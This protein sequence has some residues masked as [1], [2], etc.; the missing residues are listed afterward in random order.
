MLICRRRIVSGWIVGTFLCVALFLGSFPHPASPQIAPSRDLPLITDQAST[1]DSLPPYVPGEVLVKFKKGTSASQKRGLHAGAVADLVSEIRE[2]GVDRV[3]SVRGEST[4]VLL[5]RYRNSPLVEYAEPNFQVHTFAIPNDPRFSELWGLHNTG[6]SGGTVDAD[7]DGPEAWD[8]QTGSQQ[9]IVADVDTGLHA[10]HADLAAN[11][12]TNPGEIPNNHIDDDGNGYVDDYQGWDFIGNQPLLFD[13]NGH[14]THTA[15][16]MG[17]VGNNSIGVVGVSWRVK[18]MSVRFLDGNGTGDVADGAQAIVYAASMGAR[19]ANN[20]WGC[21]PA[22]NCYSQV[23]EDAITYANTRGMLVVAAA[24]NYQNDNDLAPVYPCNSEQPNVI[25]VAATDRNDQKA[26]FSN[27][28][29]NSVDLSAPGVDILSTVP[30]PQGCS[31]GSTICDSSGY[32]LLSGTSMAAP[33]VSGAAALLLSQFPSL[34]VLELKALLLGSVDRVGGNT[35]TGGRLNVNRAIRTNFIVSLSPNE[36]VI[37]PGGS[38][39]YTVTVTT[40]NGFAGPV[41]LSFV[42]P[43]PSFAGTF[44]SITVSPGP[45]ASANT[46]LSV[47]HSGGGQAG[48]YQIVVQ[49]RDPA[50]VTGIGVA[51]L[52]IG[53]DLAMEELTGPSEAGGGALVMVSDRVRNVGTTDWP[54][55]LVVSYYLSSDELIT[56]DDVKIGSRLIAQFPAG[57]VN[58][59]TTGVTIPLDLQSGTYVLGAIIDPGGAVPDLDR[60]NNSLV[61][62]TLNVVAG[63]DR[64]PTQE[65]SLRQAFGSGIFTDTRQEILAVD[66]FGNVFV[67]RQDWNGSSTDMWTA[68]ID[69]GGNEVWSANYDSGIT[70]IATAIWVDGDGNVYVTGY[71][72]QSHW[73]L[74]FSEPGDVQISANPEEDF[75]TLK[76]DP[77]GNLMWA[78]RYDNGAEDYAFAISG[79]SDGNVYVTGISFSSTSDF[80]TIKYDRDGNQLWVRRYDNG[81]R[82]LIYNLKVDPAGNVY[83]SGT[84][85]GATPSGGSQDDYVTIKYDTN[86]TQR[87]VRRAPGGWVTDLAVDQAGNAYVTGFS[88]YDEA[89]GASTPSHDYRTIKYDSNGNLL[90]VKRYDH[91]M[92]D[93]PEAVAVD[94]NGNV[95]VTGFSL[96]DYVNGNNLDLDFATVKYDSSGNQQWVARFDRGQDDQPFDLTVDS[97][98]NAYVTGWSCPQNCVYSS[99]LGGGYIT[100]KY[101]QAGNQ[102]WIVRTPEGR[103]PVAVAVDAT[104]H[105]YVTG[106]SK[107]GS[108]SLPDYLTVKY[109]QHGFSLSPAPASVSVAVG[110]SANYT[111]TVHSESGFSDPVSVSCGPVQSTPSIGCAVLPQS[112]TPPPNGSIDITMTVTTSSA[113]P[114]G[115]FSIMVQGTSG[116]EVVSTQVQLHV[117]VP[118]MDLLMNQVTPGATSVPVGGSLPITDSVFNQGLTTTGAFRIHYRLSLNA[119]YGDADDVPVATTRSVAGLAA[120]VANSGST[121]IGIPATAAP[122]SYRVCG[123]ADGDG[124]VNEADEGN[125]TL[126]SASTVTLT[127]ADL[128]LT[129]VSPTA[130]AAV[131]GGLLAVS[132]TVRNQGAAPAAAFAVEMHLS[133]DSTY[134]GADDFALTPT[135]SVSS[136]AVG[137]SSSATITLTVPATIGLGAYYVCAMADSA[138]VINEGTFEGNNTACSLSPISVIADDAR[139]INISTRSRVQTGDNVMIGGFWISGTGSKTVL[140]RARGGSLGGAPFNNP[141]VLANPTMQLYSGSTVIAQNSDWQTTDPLCGSPA[142]ACGGELEITAT[143]LDPCQPNPG[144]TVAPPGCAQESALLVTL[145]PGGY[146]AIVSGVGGTSGMGLVEVFEISSGTST[147]VNISTRARVQTGDNVMIG[148]FWIGGTTPKNVLIRARGGS[149]GGAPFNNPGVLAN[150]YM[151]LYSGATVIAQSDNWQTTDPLCGSPATGCGTAT[152]ITATGLDPC[153]PNPG[154]TVAPPG[155]SQESAILVTLAPGGYTTIV[156]GVGGT[157]GMGLVEVFEVP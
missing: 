142:T 102:V 73:F 81:G 126:C 62:G 150:P 87:W 77:N 26:S 10:T 148:G 80:A 82:E 53:T 103:A 55:Y 44:N 128:I 138:Q 134:G 71:R 30:P 67:T 24:G 52:A 83:V 7:I 127:V 94:Q 59:S 111:V 28:G 21:G 35:V 78:R 146:T 15:G 2:I 31:L 65:W 11:I 5:Q 92:S 130:T 129:A 156:S 47:V 69:S 106:I 133:A 13:T 114:L 79:D 147:L 50:G 137:V 86:G 27:W 12:W 4:E 46:T 76:Y 153:Q 145:S 108:L 36:H 57:S 41:T 157:S 143:G 74:P 66:S 32:R 89:V 96:A 20:S 58:T 136:L 22:V 6:Q 95:Y 33:H 72:S 115:L 113:T 19:I 131:P 17:A 39:T 104:Q 51:S 68:K 149:L 135:R 90:W 3:R 84:S 64:T 37:P 125:N 9:V 43:D 85:T 99:S 119:I 120:G 60:S 70:D 98:G 144:Q 25:C 93:H 48:R 63:P 139:M 42:A 1:A 112:V 107:T 61:G 23:L 140:I 117:G 16:I 100:V 109:T 14:G 122:G 34:T 123:K 38:T 154:Q 121:T 49:G 101:D 155:C 110:S 91:G 97:F 116:G 151:Q 56:P 18:I 29:A 105:V 152:Q 124:A 75:V 88:W 54:S 40:K 132:T 8:R 118:G 45:D 141:G